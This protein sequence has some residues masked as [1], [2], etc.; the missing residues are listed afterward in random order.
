MMDK[1]LLSHTDEEIG[2]FIRTGVRRLRDERAMPSLAVA[3]LVDAALSSNATR[4]SVAVFGLS[5]GDEQRGDWEVTL[6]KL[7]K[8]RQRARR[9]REIVSDGYARLLG[10]IVYVPNDQ[11]VDHIKNMKKITSLTISDNDPFGKGTPAA[12]R[13]PASK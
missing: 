7:S 4:M 3:M 1:D 5:K 8:W 11:I 13:K 6:R 10:R 9:V 12:P 2:R